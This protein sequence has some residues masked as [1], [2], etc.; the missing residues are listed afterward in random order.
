[1]QAASRTVS[2]IVLLAGIGLVAWSLTAEL[3]KEAF[4]VGGCFAVLGAIGLISP[5]RFPP[6]AS[7][8]GIFLTIA[9]LV[10]L[11][12]GQEVFAGVGVITALFGFALRRSAARKLD[13]SP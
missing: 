12:A 5:R 4:C 1:M 3:G 7:S 8:L 6:L 13:D 2:L 10:W 9:S 11:A